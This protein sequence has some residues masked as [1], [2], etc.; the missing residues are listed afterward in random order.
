VIPFTLS[1]LTTHDF[2]D[3]LALAAEQT[4]I[5]ILS[6]NFDNMLET[7]MSFVDASC[8]VVSMVNIPAKLLPKT[9]APPDG[10]LDFDGDKLG[11]EEGPVDGADDFEGDKLGPKEGLNELD[12][13]D[14]G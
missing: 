10:R 8:V 9:G 1:T 14:D 6:V 4:V 7:A 2:T 5:R 3:E 12:G 11:S 13:S